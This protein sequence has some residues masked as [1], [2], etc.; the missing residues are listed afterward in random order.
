MELMLVVLM[1]DKVYFRETG[2]IRDKE[3]SWEYLCNGILYANE[4]NKAT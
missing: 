1:L 3:I 2:P 4:H